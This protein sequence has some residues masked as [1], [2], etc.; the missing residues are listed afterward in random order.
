MFIIHEH[1]GFVAWLRNLDDI[2]S[3]A[4]I[5]ARLARARAGNLGD[6]KS[7]GS[8]LCEMRVDCGPGYRIYFFRVKSAI[9]VVLAGGDKSTQRRDI[10]LAGERISQ[11]RKDHSDG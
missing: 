9:Y 1:E 5:V 2:R 4:R 7:V 3:K 6:F 11:W 10:Q 8:G